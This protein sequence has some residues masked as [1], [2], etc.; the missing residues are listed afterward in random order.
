MGRRVVLIGAT[1]AFGE[2][3][4]RKLAAWPQVDLVLAARS[5]G[6]LRRLADELGCEAAVFDRARPETLATLK[7]WAVIDA[8]GPF[9]G[10]GYDLARATIAAG[11][12]Y[13]DLADGRDFVAGFAEALDAEA[14]AAGVLA[15]AGASSTPALSNAALDAMTAGWR[16]IT[17]VRAAIS[18]GAQAPRGLS[19]VQA[20]LSYTGQPVRIFSG[21]AW[22]TEP[23]WSG[24]R[25]V[26]MPG[27]G[28]RLVVLCDTPDLDVMAPR[29]T[30]EVRFLAG[31]ELDIMQWGLWLLS[32]PVRL[33]LVRSL[34]PMAGLLREVAGWLAPFGSDRGGMVVEAWGVDAAGRPAT[35]RWW[36]CA[37]ANA[38][39]TT[40]V[41]AAAAVLR[42]LLEDRIVARGA[43]PCV[44][45]VDLPA[46]L[47]ELADL[48]IVTGL[49]HG[50]P[51]APSLL[52]RMLGPGVER[53]PAQVAQIHDL[54]AP[55][56][57]RG[58]GRARGSGGL[59]P[60]LARAVIGLPDPGV[61]PDLV[62]DITPDA[63]GER[64]A[65]SFGRRRFAS[66]LGSLATPG[67]FEEALGP[68]RFR[69]LAEITLEGFRWRFQGWRLGPIPMPDALGPR[70]RA[71]S[72][73]RDGVYRFRVVTAH[74]WF[75][76]IFA[77][78][79]RLAADLTSPE[80][81]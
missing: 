76:L 66:R 10:A 64:W 63:G 7:P 37:E 70:I 55:I 30:R 14:R 50:A 18:P 53:L 22:R 54:T 81:R 32:W 40:P 33:G 43:R 78:G 48:P 59:V 34:R 65:R 5:E 57:L 25:R 24:L 16:E 2:R 12:H 17:T 21:G 6:P 31:I 38:G 39:P 28:R 60:R 67:E 42:G 71:Y 23:G 19:V 13:I 49:D 41:A 27:L 11:A 4:A 77:Y 58:A 1:G 68:L 61:Y 47:A 56:R 46:I 35:A 20:I 80:Q 62:V 8:A 3:L 36:L 15:V 75:G 69:F 51:T 73:A 45:V 29:V 44:G 72:F 52:R 26:A 74:P 9:Q 79:G